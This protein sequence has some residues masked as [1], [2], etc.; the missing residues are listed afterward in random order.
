MA[1]A[2]SRPPMKETASGR[3][4]GLGMRGTKPKTSVTEE[5]MM[6]RKRRAAD[7]MTAS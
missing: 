7:S 4:K 5:S 6:G 3:Q 1:V 2:S